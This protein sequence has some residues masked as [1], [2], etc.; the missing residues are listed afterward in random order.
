M[1]SSERTTNSS[2]VGAC[3][4]M[5]L[6]SLLRIAI[7]VTCKNFATAYARKARPCS[8]AGARVTSSQYLYLSTL[9]SRLF[10]KLVS[11]SIGTRIKTITTENH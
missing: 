3:V 2:M 9:L 7:T 4:E 5:L 1:G 8:S 11:S 10:D 6:M